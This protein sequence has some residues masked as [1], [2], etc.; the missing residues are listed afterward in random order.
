M[1]SVF[2]PFDS[3]GDYFFPL[4]SILGVRISEKIEHFTHRIHPDRV[5]L[6]AFVVAFSWCCFS[7]RYHGSWAQEPAI[8]RGTQSP[9]EKRKESSV[10]TGAVQVSQMSLD[11][12][13][14]FTSQVMCP[15]TGSSPWI[16]GYCRLGAPHRCSNSDACRV[17][18][19][20]SHWFSALSKLGL[21]A[22]ASNKL[23]FVE[24]I[25]SQGR[26]RALS[27]HHRLNSEMKTCFSLPT[28][29]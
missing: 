11:F 7:P 16:S 20:I 28:V 29:C 12:H 15:P 8:H 14:L 25:K 6:A 18:W 17:V 22:R 5:W 9:R 27:P 21:S 23:G 2:L 19:A 24:G 10:A 1:E 13:S 4:F 3:L 26:D